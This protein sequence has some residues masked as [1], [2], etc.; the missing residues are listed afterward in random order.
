MKLKFTIPDY[1]Q[2]IARILSKEGYEVYLVGGAIRDIA[3]GKTPNDYDL[4]TN[5]LPDEMLEL[6]PKSVSTGAK[7]GTVIALVEDSKKEN[8]DVEVTTFRSEEEYIDGRWPS[9]VKFVD[10]IYKDLGRRDFT[11]NAMAIDLPLE[12]L[13]S[14]EIERDW[15]VYDPFGGME[16]I[17]LKLVRA[18]GTPI[19]RFKEDGLR[20][21]KACRLASQLEFEIERDTFEAI[22]EC[23]P[24]AKQVSMERIRDEFMKLLL[25]SPKPSKG[26]DLMRESGL[27]QIFLPELLEGF[28][29]EQ[30]LYHV[31]DVYWHS[32][33]TCDYAEDSVKLAALLHDIAKPRTDMGNGHFYGHDVMGV[34]MIETIMK[35]LRFS[36]TEIERVKTLVRNH[37]FYY[38]HSQQEGKSN[39]DMQLSQWS[40]SAVR[41]FLNRVG[42]E[43]VEDLFKLRI[44]DATSNPN[45]P[46]NP[47]EITQLQ[48]HISEVRAKDMALKVSDLDITGEDLKLIGVQAGPAMGKILNALLDI[49]IE[50]PLMNTKEKL[51]DEAK[52]ML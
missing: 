10:E 22:K 29:V 30:K 26:I 20:A 9:K 3:M 8:H 12:L 17:K 34:E 39:E 14:Q 52:H 25:K 43:N 50:D 11:I 49:V 31:H 38:P 40:D 6:F 47:E 24:I 32:L 18:V 19:E 35:R 36:K 2:K 42:E 16:D 45:S 46:F 51:L 28:G 44:A 21:F 15:E 1:I 41:R 13:D 37:M 7:F 4:A 5:A 33:K 27:L 23:I 48:K